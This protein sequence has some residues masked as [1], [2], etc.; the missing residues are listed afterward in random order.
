MNEYLTA[1]TDIVMAHEGFIDKY[2]GDAI[3]GVFGAPADDPEHALHAVK[4]ALASR[5]RLHEMNAGGLTVPGGR[6]LHQRIGLHTGVGI[7]GNIGSQAAVQLHGHGRQREHGFEDRRGQQGLRNDDPGVG[8]DRPAR[9]PSGYLARG[10]YCAVSGTRR[11]RTH[12]RA[13][14]ACRRRDARGFVVDDRVRRRGCAAGGRRTSRVPAEVSSV[15]PRA[16]RRLA[17]FCS[18]AGSSSRTRPPPAGIPSTLSKASEPR[19]I[20]AGSRARQGRD[21]R[22]MLNQRG[23]PVRAGAVAECLERNAVLHC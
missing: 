16:I 6:T 12:L 10:R 11:P 14:G 5:S 17:S 13:D 8:G 19:V 7:V 22:A 3:D 1:M 20:G 2:I 21:G 4:S 23:H 9:R 15:S 18:A